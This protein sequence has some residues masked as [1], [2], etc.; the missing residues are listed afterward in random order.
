MNKE[1]RVAK[2]VTNYTSL[3]YNQKK[4]TKDLFSNEIKKILNEDNSTDVENKKEK[5]R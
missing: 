2:L 1:K 4:V 5:E 3:D